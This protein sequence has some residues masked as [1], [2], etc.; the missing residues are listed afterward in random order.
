MRSVIDSLLLHSPLQPIAAARSAQRLVVLAYHGVTDSEQ[1]RSQAEYLS[2][3]MSPVS[4]SEVIDALSHPKKTLPERAVLITFDDADRTLL[5]KGL[6][7]LRKLQVPAIAF[8]IAGHLGTRR[9]FWWREVEQLLDHGGFTPLLSQ[10]PKFAVRQLKDMSD[11]ERR[12]AIRQLR[13]SVQRVQSGENQLTVC[14]LIALRAGGIEIGN[15]TVTHPLLDRCS[16]RRIRSEIVRAHRILG[17]ALGIAPIAFAY[18]NGNWHHEAARTLKE[19]GYQAGFL[20]D[21]RVERIAALDR[22]RISRVRV[23]SSTPMN[24]FRLIVSG[25][26]PIIHRAIRRS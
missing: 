9:P 24:R 7:I 16:D 4:L 19:L 2:R 20:F 18:P 17:N 23:S 6:P 22:F 8:V 15:H 1:F 12:R 11:Q 5:E 14:D 13:R 25:L 26:H 3:E 21:H 10:T